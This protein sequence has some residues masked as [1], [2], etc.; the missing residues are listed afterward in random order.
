MRHHFL[1]RLSAGAVLLL[2]A[3]CGDRSILS[4]GSD[5]GAQPV[6]AKPVKSLLPT[7]DIA[8]ARGW[9]EGGKPLAAAGLAVN[10][11]AAGLDHPR[12]LPVLPN[13][14]VLVA[15]ANAPER[16]GK[17]GIRSYVQGKVQARAGAAVP[18]ANR[19]TLLRDADGDGVAEVK[20]VFLKGLNSPFGMALIGDMLYVANTDAI[21]RFPYREGV[22]EITAGGQ[23]VAALPGGPL[24][25]HWTKS[26]IASQDG[27]RL[28]ATSGS[29]SNVA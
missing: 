8:P 2:L 25:H 13:G 17:K 20:T 11:Y 29:N 23:P 3:A 6:I 5:L 1:P 28:Y 16:P 15:E 12:W 26:I 14:D 22:T 27:R 10:A 4:A 24:N 21:V 7:V 19:I 9:P 18:S